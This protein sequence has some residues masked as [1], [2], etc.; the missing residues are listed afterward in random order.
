M[1]NT[2]NARM[3]NSEETRSIHNTSTS[4][5]TDSDLQEMQDGE[6]RILIFRMMKGL[7][8]SIEEMKDEVEALR[9]NQKE[10]LNE[11]KESINELKTTIETNASRLDHMENRVSLLEDSSFKTENTVNDI[12][13]TLQQHTLAIQEIQD[14]ARRPNLRI[15]GLEEGLEAQTKGIRNLFKEIISENFPNIEKD[16]DI[17]IQETYRTPLRQDQRRTSPR[18]VI[19]KMTNVEAKERILKAVRTKE[20][21]TY[22]G[23]TIKITP[24]FS[25]QVRNARRDWYEVLRTLEENNFQP[26][27]KCPAAII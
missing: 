13:K 25:T 4:E 8:A 3:K 7:K 22:R 27:L 20:R 10:T 12:Q 9:K 11:M 23:K 15:K 1:E 18:H 16:V 2:E 26:R 5:I 14:N 21:V 17:H 24:D 19:I 6:F